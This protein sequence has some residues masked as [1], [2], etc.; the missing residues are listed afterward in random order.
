MTLFVTVLL[1]F[2]GNLLTG[3][4]WQ[5]KIDFVQRGTSSSTLLPF[6]FLSLQTTYLFV[7][8]A[9]PSPNPLAP[10][11]SLTVPPRF[12]GSSCPNKFPIHPAIRGDV[13]P[14]RGLHSVLFS[15]RLAVCSVQFDVVR[16]C[17]STGV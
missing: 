12:V 14:T 15:Q 4:K 5:W 1:V 3:R 17:I 16:G 9:I 6:W 2:G 10:L 11:V 13:S 8:L 7:C